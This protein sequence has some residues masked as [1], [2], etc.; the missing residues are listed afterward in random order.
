MA[1]KKNPTHLLID[2]ASD[3]MCY[4]FNNKVEEGIADFYEK[5][6]D[7]ESIEEFRKSVIVFPCKSKVKYTIQPSKTIV[8]VK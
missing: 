8:K 6:Y 3:D 7:E 2:L 1:K 5:H 4:I